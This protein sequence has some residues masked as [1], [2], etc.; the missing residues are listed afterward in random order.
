MDINEII[1]KKKNINFNLSDSDMNYDWEISCTDTSDG[2][3]L[4]CVKEKHDDIMIS[5]NVYYYEHGAIEKITDLIKEEENIIIK[6]WDEDLYDKI[7]FEDIADDIGLYEIEYIE[8]LAELWE[9][10]CLES[11]KEKLEVDGEVD[12]IARRESFNNFADRLVR[13]GKI[14]QSLSDEGLPYKYEF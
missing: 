12:F 7:D 13:E 1:T 10:S 8:E 9:N 4:W 14:S 2:F 11:I 5:E 6:F 3:E